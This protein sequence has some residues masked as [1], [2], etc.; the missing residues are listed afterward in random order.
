MTYFR[1]SSFTERSLV[2]IAQ[3]FH[4]HNVAYF[5]AT[6]SVGEVVK[7]LDGLV[8]ELD[9]NVSRFQASLGCR[10]IRSHIGE[11]HA[12]FGLAEIRDRAE[13]RPV[14]APP[15]PAGG[16]SSATLETWAGLAYFAIC[17]L[18]F[19]EVQQ[20]GRVGGIDFVPGV[21]RLVIVG[22]KPREKEKDRNLLADKR[23]VV[24]GGV[25]TGGILDLEG[26]FSEPVPATP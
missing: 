6:Q 22:V 2:A 23:R 20:A 8:A 18:T 7:I 1:C 15:P 17:I 9:Q 13:I 5:A 3:D 11:L 16:F 10:R 24:A 12:L 14:T 4:F 25:A 19:G 21:G 26:E